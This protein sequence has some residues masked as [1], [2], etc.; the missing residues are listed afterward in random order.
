M[1]R[2]ADTPAN[3]QTLCEGGLRVRRRQMTRRENSFS[4]GG[5]RNQGKHVPLR[6]DL[7]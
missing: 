5:N 6:H 3:P 1:T 2:N 4:L 7:S